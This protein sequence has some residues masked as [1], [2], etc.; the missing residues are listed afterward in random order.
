MRILIVGYD[1]PGALERHCAAPLREMGH[2]VRF[3]DIY[4]NITRRSHFTQIPLLSEIESKLYGVFFNRGLT[5]VVTQWQ[6]SLVFVF[7]GVELHPDT[8]RRLRA[9]HNRPILVNWNPDSP[10][11]YTTS[12]TNPW[13]IES[14]PLYDAYFI[15][16]RDVT[17]ALVEAGAQCVEY[18]PFGY[19]PESHRPVQIVAE[20]RVSLRSQICFVG[21]YTPARARS[22]EALADL[23]VRIWGTGWERLTKGSPLRGR[24]MGGWTH[25]LAMSKVFLS[26]D[27]VMNFIR[28]Q[29][30][31]AHNM[32][33]FEVPAIGAFMLATRT[34]EQL[35]WL[36]E[37]EAAD[38]FVDIEEMYKKA[39]YYVNRPDER[40][41][42][43]AEGHRR[44]IGGG[45]TYADRMRRLMRVVETL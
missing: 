41:R 32:R 36:P 25:G 19:D 28:P 21:G 20:E 35:G 39:T 34:R 8:L 30:G 5:D 10:F 11:D 23:D 17:P 12:N 9:I 24:V 15:W 26:A 16:G 38:Y 40:A 2:S 31:Q 33:T 6:P 7:K 4:S 3:H 37:G 29:N 44:I 45:H 42:I 43:A 1:T 13:L 22:L 27:I 18:L 14:I